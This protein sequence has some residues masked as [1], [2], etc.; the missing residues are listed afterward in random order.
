MGVLNSHGAGQEVA[1]NARGL[2]LVLD[3]VYDQINVAGR[4]TELCEYCRGF[5]LV[6]R[7]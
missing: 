2:L 7:D 4:M 3:Q 5:G 1:L 6:F